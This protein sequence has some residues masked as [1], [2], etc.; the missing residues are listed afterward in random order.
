M[1]YECAQCGGLYLEPR[2]E[3]EDCGHDVVKE[4]AAQIEARAGVKTMKFDGGRHV[5]TARKTEAWKP[6]DTNPDGRLASDGVE[7]PE[8]KERSWWQNFSA[9]R[10]WI[11][12]VGGVRSGLQLAGVA[13]FVV[14][15]YNFLFYPFIQADVWFGYR[16]LLFSVAGPG[17]APEASLSY[18]ADFLAM[19]A[20]AAMAWFA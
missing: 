15:A 2:D 6:A 13:L 8:P 12:L 11:K 1:A 4:D 14:A 7:T 3:C 18:I 5:S 9:E 10:V 19:M 16:E 20:G 17:A